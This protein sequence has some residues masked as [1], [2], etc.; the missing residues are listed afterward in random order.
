MNDAPPFFVVGAQRSGTTMLRLMLDSHPLIAVP[1]ES[2]FIVDFH[3]R[4]AEY[5]DLALPSSRARL[6][7]DIA[8]HPLVRKGNL[9]PDPQAVLDSVPRSYAALVDAIFRTY[10]AREGKAR[11]GDKTPS[12][13]TDIDVLRRLFPRCRVVHLVRDGRDVA[14]SN[15]NVDWGIRSLPRVA[16]DWRWKTVLAHK[17]GALLGDDYCLV[18]YEDLVR[19][20]AATLARIAD[21]LGVAYDAC[22]LRYAEHGEARMPVDSLRWHRNS[23]RPPDVELVEQ[24]KARMRASDRILFEQCAGDALALFGYPLER[25]A[26]TVASRLRNLYF[27]TVQRY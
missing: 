23:V 25:R 7:D 3:A 21:F 6:L 22:M 9:V 14:L 17:V 18:R 10:A 2:G 15:R 8:R 1:F 13:V 20:P 11:W 4:L 27:A 26:S 16:S 12:Y 19:E 5:A 24:W